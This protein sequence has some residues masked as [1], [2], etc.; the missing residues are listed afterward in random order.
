MNSKIS[1]I[2]NMNKRDLERL[3]KAERTNLVEKLQNKARKPTKKPSNLVETLQNKA[4]K[5]KIAIVKDNN[6]KVPQPQKPTRSIPPRDPKTSQFIKI[7]LDRPKT[8]KAT[9][10]TKVKGCKGTIHL[11]TAVRTCST[12]SVHSNTN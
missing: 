10:L 7:H 4:R 12:T 6:G 2:M 5:P 11:K 9:H 3:S 8:S 1:N